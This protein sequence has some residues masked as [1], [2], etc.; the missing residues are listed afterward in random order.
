MAS[1]HIRIGI[2]PGYAYSMH[3]WRTSSGNARPLTAPAAPSQVQCAQWFAHRLGFTPLSRHDE[4][5][6]HQALRLRDRVHHIDLYLSTSTLHKLLMLMDKHFLMLEHL[7]L[8]FPADEVKTLTLPKT[9]LAPNLRH[10]SLRGIGLPKR[11]RLLSSTISLVTLKLTGI[12]SSGYFR[13]RLLVARLNTLPQLEEPFIEFSIP[14]PRL[15]AEVL[16]LR[17]RGAPVILSNLKE[18]KFRDVGA[19]LKCLISQI[20]APR[21]ER[22]DIS[23]F[24]QIAFTLPHLS[25]FVNMT[26]QIKHTIATISFGH[27]GPDI[28]LRR[29]EG[30]TPGLRLR[31]KCEPMD[32]KIDCAAQICS[33]LISALSGIEKL[34]LGYSFGRNWSGPAEIDFQND[35]IDGTMWHELLR[36][37]IGLR[38][39]RIEHLLSELSRALEVD[40]IGSDPGFLPDLKEIVIVTNYSGVDAYH[41]FSSFMHARRMVGRPISLSVQ[42]Q[43]QGD[44]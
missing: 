28:A 8:S 13:P 34:T 29:S 14:T 24:N 42:D 44:L 17:R 27:P 36:S 31:V 37:F 41:L 10:L 3:E 7:S 35:E 19:Y 16:L 15:S 21:L 18:L 22:L 12:R 40:E 2:S 6:I 20:R 23:L 9:F 43:F 38:E 26:E 5:G 32:W 1:P 30:F 11:L 25:H 39:L 4:A 33:A